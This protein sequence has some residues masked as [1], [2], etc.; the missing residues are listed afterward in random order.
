MSQFLF[1]LAW[2]PTRRSA[3]EPWRPVKKN[4][5]KNKKNAILIVY[6]GYTESVATQLIDK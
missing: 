3:T 4:T 1:S 5:N 2:I 6:Q